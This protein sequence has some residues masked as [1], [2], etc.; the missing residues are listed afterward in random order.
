[1]LFVDCFVTCPVNSHVICG[2]F[3]HMSSKRPCYLWIVLSYRV[4]GMELRRL[5]H[6]PGRGLE[7]RHVLEASVRLPRPFQEGTQQACPV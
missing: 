1:M 2:L 7:L 3:C 6:V 5:Q 4:S